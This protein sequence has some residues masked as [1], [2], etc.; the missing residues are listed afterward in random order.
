[1]N[2]IVVETE[3]EDNTSNAAARLRAATLGQNDGVGGGRRHEA[4]RMGCVRP[5]T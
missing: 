4:Q 3:E 2:T 1:M 5:G